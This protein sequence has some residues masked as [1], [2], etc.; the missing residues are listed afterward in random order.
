MHGSRKFCQRGMQLRPVLFLDEEG[1]EDP[2]TTISGSPAPHPSGSAHGWH[3]PSPSLILVLFSF[4]IRSLKKTKLVSLL[5]I[6]F[7]MLLYWSVVGV[8]HAESFVRGGGGVQLRRF[9]CFCLFLLCVFLVN[10]GK[11]KNDVWL[12]GRRCWLGSFVIFQG[13][14]TCIAKEPYSFVIFQG[15]GGGGGGYGSAHVCNC[16]IFWSNSIVSVV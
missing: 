9:C 10:K 16:G 6:W 2:N 11:T 4:A 3:I 1:R 14:R 15:G 13:L 5:W 12:A 8:C 7:C